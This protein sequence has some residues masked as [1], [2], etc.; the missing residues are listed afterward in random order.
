MKLCIYHGNT[1][2]VEG[3]DGERISHMC[4]STGS[5]SWCEGDRQNNWVWVK[6]SPGRCYGMLNGRLL[7]QLQ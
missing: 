2:Q 7:W 5:Q 1:V 4:Q 6:Q 3:L